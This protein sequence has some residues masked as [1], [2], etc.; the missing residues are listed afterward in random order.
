MKKKSFKQVEKIQ[1]KFINEYFAN[2]ECKKY[3]LGCGISKQGLMRSVK[4]KHVKDEN[5][6]DLCLIVSLKSSEPIKALPDT[7]DGVS[8]YYQIRKV[9]VP[10]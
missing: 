2:E 8:V 4:R 6:E 7:Y 5:L 10:Y 9:A 3:F 1:D